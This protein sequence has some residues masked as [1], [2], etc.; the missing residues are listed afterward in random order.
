MMFL[1]NLACGTDYRESDSNI[2]WLNV[3]ISPNIR[4]D[5]IV[6]AFKLPYPFPDDHFDG[7]L[8]QDFLEHVPHQLFDADARPLDRDGFL[9][10]MD[11]IWR[12]LK[13]GAKLEAR[14]PSPFHPNSLI[15]P[16]HTRSLFPQTFLW[17]LCKEGDFS[18]YTTRHWQDLQFEEREDGNI[19]VLITKS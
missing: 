12:I 2:H 1:L 15:D 4:T 6:N 11:E 3:D 17:Y 14:F 18:F 8:A 7:V 5:L 9:L 19:V 10:V 16:T 13:P